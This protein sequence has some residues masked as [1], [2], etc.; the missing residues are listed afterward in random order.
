MGDFINHIFE[1]QIA[2]FFGVL[3]LFWLLEFFLL[4]TKLSVKLSHTLLNARFLFFVVPVQFSLSVLVLLVSNH[5]EINQLG[6]MFALPVAKDSLVY[7]ILTFIIIDLFD[8]LYHY[9]MHKVP[10][11]WKFHQIH[12]SDLDVDITTTLREHPVETF[13]RVSYSIL[14][15]LLIGATPWFLILKQVLQSTSNILSHS[16]IK[17]PERVNY[18]VS[19]IFVTPNTHHVH[20]HYQLP[21]TDSNF[22]DVLTVWDH[23]FATFYI[24]KPSKIVYGVDTNMI[25]VENEN[26]RNLIT[27]P[28][29]SNRKKR[30][31]KRVLSLSK[32]RL[33]IF[34]LVLNLGCSYSQT[35]VS[36]KVVD[37][38]QKPVANAN[39]VFTGIQ[40]GVLTNAN[41]FFT[42]KSSQTLS[43]ISINYVGYEPELV[44]LTA[45]TTTDLIVVLKN[46]NNQLDEITIKNKAKVKLKKK[47]N[48]AYAILQNIWKNKRKNGLKLADYYQYNKY[49]STELGID[50][51]DSVFVK[52]ALKKNFDS[53]APLMKKQND[54]IYFVPIALI[55]NYETVYGNNIL[56][57]ERIDIEGQRNVGLKQQNKLFNNI[58]NTFHEVDFYQNNI[59]LLNKNFVS[60]ISS[61]GFGTYNYELA[62]SSFVKNK[63]FYTIKFKPKIAR[64]F[65]FRG[66][67]IVDSKNYALTEI[68][69]ITPRKMSLNFV[70]NF[71]LKK[72]F[73]Y[74]NDSIYLP[75]T[76]EYKGN[77][78][79]IS[80][81][82]EENGVYVVK[83]ENF[84]NYNLNTPKDPQFYNEGVK[85]ISADQFT[86]DNAYWKSKEDLE[87]QNT[88]QIVE[89]TKDSKKLKG[90]TDMIYIIADGYVPLVKGLQT[91]NIWATAARNQVEGLRWRLGLRTFVTDDDRLRAEGFLAY[92]DKDNKFK[93]GL[94]A[95]YLLTRGI[96][97]T[98]SAA[99]LNDNEQMGLI[100]FN[101]SHLLPVADKSSKALFVRGQNHF[102]SKID[103]KMIR[104]DVQPLK[105]LHTGITLTHNTIK[106]AAADR[107]SL[108]YIDPSS[109]QIK[110][111][112]TDVTSDIYLT[113]TPGKDI[114]GFGVDEKQSV[115]LHPTLK[116]N[117]KHGFKDVMNGSFNYNRIQ[118]LY[119]K[120]ISFGKTGILDATIGAGKTFGAVPLAILTAVSSNQTY[121]LLP[122]T[123][124]LLNYYDFVADTYIEGHFEQHFNG[125]ILNEIPLIK[126]LDWRSLI[127]FR[128][129]TGT[130]SDAN[131]ALNKSSIV[132]TAPTK[133]YFE[134]GCGI[135]NIGFGNIRPIRLD[136]I[137]R[138]PFKE[139]NQFPNP[140][141]GIRVGL[142]TTF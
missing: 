9:M 77:F 60:P 124:A 93:Y 15:I 40:G 58:V 106:S 25:R 125:L 99:Y 76:N 136:F 16:Q 19:K 18:F 45:K 13:I 43:D 47:E 35:V 112:T 12:H 132:Y 91:G 62:D 56:K 57:K 111:L 94:E 49:S 36:G 64:D 50:N 81:D 41:G 24:L 17:L 142:K 73:T 129:V 87:T 133:L 80:N 28:F 140:K 39:V 79:L 59:L 122:N 123:F 82:D 98:L 110:S 51:L 72:T 63:K 6:F 128:C 52:K 114:S 66:E 115:K 134:Y 3:I 5:V 120:P 116:I 22:G 127:T 130:I 31:Q 68:E 95:R 46:Q 20:H 117:Y 92:G 34:V 44:H 10:L 113:Y 88:F 105:N 103:K 118:M 54:N 32:I 69:M 83:K 119:N 8:Y 86:Q 2:L 21:F 30:K 85:Q 48:P 107:F 11:F 53:I 97:T 131:I 102:L 23:V 141:F 14:V 42:I 1:F 4:P 37:R 71:E 104:F 139:I 84:S 138:S 61:E 121:F 96:R 75:L 135:E 7:F 109:N 38:K 100:E 67:F 55:E 74:K 33:L 65:A 27:R 108:D 137:W 89:E 78:T 70:R 101:D 29:I 126:K 26:F 90:I